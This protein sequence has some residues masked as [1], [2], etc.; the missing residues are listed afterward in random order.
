MVAPAS[1][2]LKTLPP[3]LSTLVARGPE[4]RRAVQAQ[5]PRVCASL[6]DEAVQ[7]ALLVA[8]T[9]RETWEAVWRTHGEHRLFGRLRLTTWRLVRAWWRRHGRRAADVAS[10]RADAVET[11][12]TVSA[13]QEVLV[14]VRHDL[15]RALGRAV[16]A[17][18]GGDDR[19]V[20]AILVD[21]LDTG[22]GDTELAERHGVRR[23][24]VNRARNALRREVWG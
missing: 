24:Y 20:H 19:T 16:Q 18:G 11:L 7:E 5:F 17:A 2:R 8:W 6:V 13:G 3:Y 12:R 10:D 22:A 14:R 4:A 1:R 23:E 9:D 21:A 15:P